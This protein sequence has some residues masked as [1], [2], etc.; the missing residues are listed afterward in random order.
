MLHT[1][2]TEKTHGATENGRPGLILGIDKPR[3]P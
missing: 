2:N 1:E 3:Q